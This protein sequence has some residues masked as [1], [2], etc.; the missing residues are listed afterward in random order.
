MGVAAISLLGAGGATAQA[1]QAAVP[2][3]V[4]LWP[5]GAPGAH[6]TAEGDRPALFIY[7]PAAG[8]ANG[9]AVIVCP[10][11]GYGG[12]AMDHE[13]HEVARWFASFGVTAAVLRYR[14][15]QGYKQPIPLGDAQRA[16]RYVRAN[17]KDLG[18]DPKRIGI[19]GF[20]AGG[21][22]SAS[23]A[24]SWVSGASDAADPLDRVTSRPDF[25]VLAYPVIT[26][27]SPFTH[28]GSRDNLLGAKA[29][30]ELIAKNSPEQHVTRETPP[31]FLFS[32]T[33]DDVVPVENSLMFYT[34][35]RKAGVPAELHIYR[36][37]PHGMGLNRYAADATWPSLVKDW[38]E[39]LGLLKAG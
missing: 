8:K 13:G 33:N 37:G 30:A 39:N 12:L 20:S 11:G 3:E 29:S 10:G 14:H 23:A 6:G 25:A 32:T 34:A 31:T 36:A 28:T 17:A 38:M 4:P 2:P 15:A 7:R 16:I 1:P 27:T 9:A 18:V 5:N 21:H 19:M 24:T 26:M 22:L 35:L